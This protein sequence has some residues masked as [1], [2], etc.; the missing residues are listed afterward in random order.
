MWG[1]MSPVQRVGGG[2]SE[3]LGTPVR[4]LQSHSGDC[5]LVAHLQMC[6]GPSARTVLAVQTPSTAALR[7]LWVVSPAQSALPVF[8]RIGDGML[9]ESRL[10]APGG[11]GSSPSYWS[12]LMK[13]ET[14]C[15]N[16]T[17]RKFFSYHPR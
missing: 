6:L 15:R 8:S 11:S 4:P 16:K 9:T 10:F 17:P 13:A 7:V 12:F 5:F 2:S 1:P 3:E 14:F